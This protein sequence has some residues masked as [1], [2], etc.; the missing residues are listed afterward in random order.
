MLKNNYQPQILGLPLSLIKVLVLALILRIILFFI[1]INSSD[2]F[3]IVD[4]RKYEEISQVYL[5]YAHSIWDWSAIYATGGDGYLQV[6]WPY[7]ICFFSKIFNTLYAGRI[8]N[9]IFSLL[10]IVQT[11]KLTD[12]II[13]KHDRSLFAA[14]LMAFLP[15]PLI[16]SVFN[17]KDFYIMLG[18]MY[19]FRIFV[20]WQMGKNV[21]LRNVLLCI[22]LLVGVYFARG[23]VVEFV[24][25][26]FGLFFTNR[27]YRK[28]Q[29][30][31]FALSIIVAVIGVFY[32]WDVIFEAFDKKLDN[33]GDLVLTANGLK[34]IQMHGLADFYK[35]PFQYLFSIISPFTINIFNIFYNFNWLSFLSLCN[36]VM[37][38]VGFGSLFYLFMKKHNALFY[39]ATFAVYI[40][41][42]S[43]VLA[44][45]RHYF[46]L[47]FL[48][49]ISF[50]CF[51]DRENQFAKGV[52]WIC[53]ML[54][55]VLVLFLSFRTL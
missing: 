32:T 14:K 51:I 55:L 31:L 41:I 18:V 25:V 28:K 1:V 10:I 22:V 47:F 36:L 7:T 23:G 54:L 16:F 42:T 15:Y 34:M 21:K 2:P 13:G 37:L 35:L 49:V 4:D 39:F 44:I 53:S 30:L 29:Y 9:I 6:F 8:L 43:M 40:A 3:I 45:F 33:Y 24:G 50:T 12:L 5:Q 19:A 38:P 27:F 46:F 11:Y 20:L 52:M 48:H 26:V 17:V